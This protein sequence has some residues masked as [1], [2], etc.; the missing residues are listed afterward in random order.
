MLT[1][2]CTFPTAAQTFFRLDRLRSYNW[3]FAR[4]ASII[5]R[6][7]FPFLF[8]SREAQCFSKSFITKLRGKCNLVVG[9]LAKAQHAAHFLGAIHM[10]KQDFEPMLYFFR[11]HCSSLLSMV[12]TFGV[13]LDDTWDRMAHLNLLSKPTK[14][15]G[16]VALFLRTL[17]SIGFT[18][19]PGLSF[20]SPDRAITLV[21]LNS[22]VKYV[23]EAA[24]QLWRDMALGSVQHQRQGGPASVRHSMWQRIPDK[25]LATFPLSKRYRTSAIMSGRA[26]VHAGLRTSA[27]C[28][29]CKADCDTKHLICECPTLNQQKRWVP[30][31]QSRHIHVIHW[32]STPA[33]QYLVTDTS[34][35]SAVVHLSQV[36]TVN[37][38]TDVSADPA[39]IA[40]VPDCPDQNF[41]LVASGP[42]PG[43]W[44]NILRAK[45][46]ALL[47]SLQLGTQATVH[48]DNSTVVHYFQKALLAG[49]A[50]PYQGAQCT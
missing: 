31:Q 19:L 10:H 32:H 9:K 50:R 48:C 30:E 16:P 18:T 2:G 37:I 40:M 22:P 27:K 26:L 17:Q 45:T 20:Q 44:Q 29:H 49:S 42:V 47:V 35:T 21:L 46:Y 23:I 24:T 28:D 6:G 43:I 3:P 12:N 14:I 4:K 15:H 34:S 1:K 11:R 25:L 7:I 13:S 41:P 39:N 8:S 33:C 5:Q 36:P 38:F